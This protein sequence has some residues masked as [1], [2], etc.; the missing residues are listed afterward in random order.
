MHPDITSHHGEVFIFFCGMA[1]RLSMGATA[2]S[3][4]GEGSRKR[5]TEKV[6]ERSM[7]GRRI[8]RREEQTPQENRVKKSLDYKEEEAAG[9]EGAKR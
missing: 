1:A 7:H 3:G 2:V 4:L 8:I 9:G 6:A 5:M